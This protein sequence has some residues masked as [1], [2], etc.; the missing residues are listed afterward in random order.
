MI[1]FKIDPDKVDFVK[2]NKWLVPVGVS[3]RHI[4]LSQE[5]IEILFGRGYQLTVAK[6]L[7]QKGN[8]AAKETVNIVGSKGVL[9]RVRIVGPPREVSQVE[10]SRTDAVK[11]GI[12][13]PIRD[14]GDL[15]NTPGAILIGPAGPLVLGKGVIIPR[16]HIHMAK[17]KAESLDLH[18]RDKVSILIKGPKVV[19]Y[20][21][22]LVRVTDAGETE[23]HIDT[24]EANAAFVDTGDLAM[25]K[26]REMVV[27]DNYG[28]I[29]EVGV[30]NI[31]FVVGKT[32]HDYAS[33]EGIRLLRNVFHYPV[34]TQQSIVNKMLNPHLI[35]PARFYLLSAMEGDKVVGISCFYYLTD[36]RLGYLE[37][38]G[39]TPEYRNRGIGSFLYHKVTSFLEKEHPEIEG[40]LL[41]VRRS[42]DETDNRK[43]FFLNL[44]AIPVDTSF[45]PSGKFKFAEELL[46][47]FKPLVVEANLNT[48]TLEQAFRNLAKVL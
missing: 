39:I 37:H 44:G 34:S 45:Y 29:V 18:D 4:H 25:I 32:P 16:A 33:I 2:S 48:I 9:E 36:S 43:Q 23:F 6:E 19:C 7:A 21:N 47:M 14:S 31:K 8:Y 20:H 40:L 1:N 5:D 35:E 28:N 46:L 30:D 26:H 12:E 24:D 13:A 27:K 41:E 22:V 17:Q 38:I 10:I 15:D 3:N 11:L 42:K